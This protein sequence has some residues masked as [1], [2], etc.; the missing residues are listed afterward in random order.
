M[1]GICPDCY[2]IN[3][4]N[5]ITCLNNFTGYKIDIKNRHP[6][7]ANAVFYKINGCNSCSYKSFCKRF[8]KVQDE[9]F[10]IFEVVIEFQHLKLEAWKNLLSPKGIEIRVNRSIQ[11]EGVFGIIKQNYGRA[12]FNRR[13]IKRVSTEAMLYFLGLNIAKLFNYYETGKQ[14]KFWIAPDNLESQT[15]KK[16]SAK[17]LSKKGKKQNEKT[18]HEK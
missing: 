1:S 17:K 4:D 6:R 9:D 11:V 8:M 18:Y 5:T 2:K 16:A 10:K 14:N 15:M 13:G 7:N 3:N 12:R